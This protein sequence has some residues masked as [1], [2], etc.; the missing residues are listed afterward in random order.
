M[1]AMAAA[2]MVFMLNLVGM[3]LGPLIVGALNDWLTPSYG[4]EA[5]RYSLT[6]AVVP[7]ALAAIFNLL[8]ARHLIADLRTAGSVARDPAAATGT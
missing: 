4:V 6:F 3:G 7:H 8:A 1:R 2:I 5:V